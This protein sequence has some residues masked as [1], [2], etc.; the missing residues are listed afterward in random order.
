MLWRFEFVIRKNEDGMKMASKEETMRIILPYLTQPGFRFGL[1]HPVQF[2]E[3]CVNILRS[4]PFSF[5]ARSCNKWA[6]RRVILTGDAAHVFPPFGGQ[7]IASGFRDAIALAWRLALL[8]AEPEIDHVEILKAWY[9]ER[10]QQ[11][12]RSLASTIRNGD[13]VTES[14]PIKIFLRDWFFWFILC[15]PSWKRDI[16]SGGRAKSMTRYKHQPGMPFLSQHCGGRQFAQIYVWNF[17]SNRVSFSDDLIFGP[18]KKFLFQLI[19]LPDTFEEAATL[20]SQAQSVPT[21]SFVSITE[22]TIIVQ[23]VSASASSQEQLNVRAAYVA[24]VATGEEFAADPVLCKNRPKPKYYDPLRMHRELDHM[25][26]VLV[27][28][29]RFVYAACK[30]STELVEIVKGMSSVLLIQK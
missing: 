5:Q 23:D 28:P 21:N 27:R 11:F 14:N 13:L 6:L 4:R 26:F 10:K 30:S 17:A 24:R 16:E 7:G 29:D 2:P 18:K 20:L 12:E 8:H 9:L 25:K 22:A 15:L 3:D 19:V 1:D